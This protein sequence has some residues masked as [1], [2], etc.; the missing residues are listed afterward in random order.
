MLSKAGCNLGTCH[1][2]QNGK[3]GFKLSLRG[4]KPDADFLTLT[5]DQVGRRVNTV[6]AENSLLLLKP[7]MSVPHEGGKRFDDDSTEYQILRRWIAAGMPPTPRG[8]PA[9]QSL[10]VTP[11]EQFVVEPDDSVQL[12]AI[13]KFADGTT[14]DVIR[15]ACFETSQPSVNISVNGLVQRERF[16]EVTVDRKSTRLNSSHVALSRMPSS[17]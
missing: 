7:T 5:H 8:E 14:R 16:G 4:Q 6:Q 3:G 17:A 9:L 12:Q 1:G 10:E 13:A 2:N 11:L 15:L